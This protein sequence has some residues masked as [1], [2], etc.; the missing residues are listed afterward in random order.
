M[1]APCRPTPD[2]DLASAMSVG[3]KGVA[4]EVPDATIR[5]IMATVRVFQPSDS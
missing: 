2:G 3:V 5:K 1:I 4:D